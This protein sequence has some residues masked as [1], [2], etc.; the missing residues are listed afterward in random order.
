MNVSVLV[1]AV[2]QI[3][4]DEK[5]K[6]WM[7]GRR[8]IRR[9]AYKCEFEMCFAAGEGAKS[10]CVETLPGC[11]TVTARERESSGTKI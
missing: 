10:V 1:A 11:R 3:E 2:L 5:V 8:M 6:S 7:I 4:V 9:V